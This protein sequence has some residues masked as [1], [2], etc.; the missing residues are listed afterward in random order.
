[1]KNVDAKYFYAEL[2]NKSEVIYDHCKD[3]LSDKDV[4]WEPYYDFS[5][6][7]ISNKLIDQEPILKKINE[8]YKIK[9]ILVV[10]LEPYET[11]VWHTD[12]TRGASINMILSPHENKSYCLFGVPIK[13][14][15]K[16]MDFYELKYNPKTFY[17]FNTQVPHTVINFDKIRYI[18]SLEFVTEYDDLKYSDLY[19]WLRNENLLID[20]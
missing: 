1:M 10:K 13:N 4:K 2:K 19:K 18:F 11:Y 8:K 16:R 15:T 6:F 7:K 20:H 17:L 5:I 3:I 12:S 14:S 9:L